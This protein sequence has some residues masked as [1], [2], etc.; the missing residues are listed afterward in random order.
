MYPFG[1]HESKHITNP[2]RRDLE[3]NI[4][5]LELEISDYDA[6]DSLKR[7]C[8]MDIVT[9][10][11]NDTGG[12]DQYIAVERDG[13]VEWELVFKATNNRNLLKNLKEVNKELNPRTVSNH[14]GT[15]AH[16]HLN[17]RYFHDKLDINLIDLQKIGEFLAYP[18]YLFSGRNE[19]YMNEWARSTLPCGLKDDLLTRAKFVDRQNDVSYNRYNIFNFNPSA[20]AELR[21]F[22]NHCNFDY[23]TIR[24]FLEVADMLMKGAEYMKEKSYEENI[25]EIIEFVDDYM[26]KYPRRSFI[27]DKFDMDSIFLSGEEL[28]HIS[29]IKQ[30]ESIDER[31]KSFESMS[32]NQNHESNV[33]SFIRMVRDLNRQQGLDLS[34]RV[35]PARMN[36][37][38]E[39]SAVRET[40]RRTLN[41]E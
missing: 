20:T 5:G 19:R 10:E 40:V 32:E 27:Y 34:W 16:I 1:Y 6:Y 18:L 22:S 13:S 37:V 33:L 23:K 4:K 21:I 29:L 30:W 24:L 38:D 14:S 9:D 2:N 25:D 3:K 28:R 12:D 17:R 31:I 7:L 36:P 26:R 15:S 11:E 39:C 41:L 35:N 8:E